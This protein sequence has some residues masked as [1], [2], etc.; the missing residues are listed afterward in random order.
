MDSDLQK[1]AAVSHVPP[2]ALIGDFLRIMSDLDGVVFD[3]RF[4]GAQ[5]TNFNKLLRKIDKWT[6]PRSVIFQHADFLNFNAIIRHFSPK[7][8]EAVQLPIKS[9]ERYYEVLKSECLSLKALHIDTTFSHAFRQS[10]RCMDHRVLK[11]VNC[12]FPQIESLVLD[13]DNFP[14]NVGPLDCLMC[15]HDV[16]ELVESLHHP[17]VV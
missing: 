10:L 17:S 15:P 9:R 4:S 3:L 14:N 6:G 8:L 12:D 1:C 13:E 16:V 5:V 7:T 11:S 2:V